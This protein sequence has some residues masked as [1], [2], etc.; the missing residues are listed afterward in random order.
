MKFYVIKNHPDGK[1][2]V[3]YLENFNSD[4]AKPAAW[5]GI[6]EYDNHGDAM[7]DAEGWAKGGDLPLVATAEYRAKQAA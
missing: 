4:D 1:I 3:S 2:R 7:H 5:C 6:G